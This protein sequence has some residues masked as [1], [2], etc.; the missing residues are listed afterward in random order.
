MTGNTTMD[1]ILF[2]IF[3]III[4]LLCREIVMWY[5]KVNAILSK[6]EQGNQLL[7]QILSELR[8][9]DS[10]ESLE[11]VQEENFFEGKKVAVTGTF[12]S[13]S[14]QKVMDR[15]EDR[16]AILQ[17]EIGMTTDVVVMGKSPD[18]LF[19]RYAD[20]YQVKRIY[21][22]ELIKKLE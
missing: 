16:K 12:D 15:L 21:E 7:Q 10:K 14:I 3:S 9:T 1:L 22:D 20:Q 19:V 2:I 18:P 8:S 17:K 4:F 11:T 5:W 6:Q 13:M